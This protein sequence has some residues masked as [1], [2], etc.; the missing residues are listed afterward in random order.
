MNLAQV[1]Q[2]KNMAEGKLAA[3]H[4]TLTKEPSAKT[5]RYRSEQPATVAEKF[6]GVDVSSASVQSRSFQGREFCVISG[7]N[8]CDKHALETSILSNGGGIVQNPTP[9]TFCVVARDEKNVRVRNLIKGGKYDIVRVDWLVEC[10]TGK[11]ILPFHPSGMLSAS[12]ETQQKFRTRF[13]EFGDDYLVDLNESQLKE[14]FENINEQRIQDIF[15]PEDA[16]DRNVIFQTYINE[17]STKYSA[18]S[19]HDL[20]TSLFMGFS[21]YVDDKLILNDSTTQNQTTESLKIASC[22]MFYGGNLQRVITKDTSHVVILRNSDGESRLQMINSLRQNS[23]HKFHI[24]SSA[25]VITSIEK[26]VLEDE[27][28]YIPI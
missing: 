21:F 3:R 5:S 22:I 13:D 27:R 25:W 10:L 9:N 11:K 4:A 7:T 18:V 14:I 8:E 2:L 15:P 19:F 23:E 6:R 12:A 26:G 16:D 24:V 17:I 28:L 20:T 1:I